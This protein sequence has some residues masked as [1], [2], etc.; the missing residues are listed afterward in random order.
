MEAWE[1]AK[2][3]EQTK[4]GWRTITTKYFVTPD[5]ETA[6]YDT[7]GKV[8]GRSGAVIALTKDNKV[9]LAR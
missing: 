5:G 4:V 9:I 2:S 3:D 7:F 8:D 1:R 6:A